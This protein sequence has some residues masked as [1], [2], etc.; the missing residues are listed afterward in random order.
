MKVVKQT[1][2]LLTLQYRP[3]GFWLIGGG[4]IIT[5]IGILIFWSEATSLICHRQSVTTDDCQQTVVCSLMKAYSNHWITYLL[6][7][8]FIIVGWIALL[9]QVITVMFDKNRKHLIIEQR[10][11]FGIKTIQD[12]DNV[13][14]IKV[15]LSW[16]LSQLVLVLRSGERILLNSKSISK[17]N[18]QNLVDKITD[19]LSNQ[20]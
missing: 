20:C 8:I 7:G 11:I 17:I 18:N 9:R 10:R 12:L 1:A 5:G 13:T 4:L 3:M 16:F 2:V 15:E 19:F 6:S 14:D